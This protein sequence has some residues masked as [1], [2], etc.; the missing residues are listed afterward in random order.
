MK[1]KK[2]KGYRSSKRV[3]SSTVTLVS[4]SAQSVEVSVS[5]VVP[6][7]VEC[8]TVSIVVLHACMFLHCTTD[9]ALSVQFPSLY[10]QQCSKRVGSS[11][12]VCYCRNFSF[13]ERTLESI[14]NLIKA[15][16]ANKIIPKLSKHF[17][18]ISLFSDYFLVQSKQSYKLPLKSCMKYVFFYFFFLLVH[19]AHDL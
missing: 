7:R 5:L 11:T 14:S 19:C 9:C 4:R 13:K 12:V 18:S 2:V 1:N 6:K 17:S 10:L 3:C 15:K 8:L 16:D